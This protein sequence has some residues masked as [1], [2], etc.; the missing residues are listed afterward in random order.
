MA[1]AP[2]N[3]FHESLNIMQTIADNVYNVE[4]NETHLGLNSSGA[5]N[6][7]LMLVQEESAEIEE[8]DNEN[9]EIEKNNNDDTQN[10]EMEKDN[11][12]NQYLET[13][14]NN[15]IINDEIANN[16]EIEENSAENAI[17]STEAEHRFWQL[18]QHLEE[19]E[20]K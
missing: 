18:R 15:E 5:L 6:S 11:D 7:T 17:Y 2:S 20:K 1:L 8:N 14:E 4:N 9:S 16:S 12:N 10:S 13:E 3:L 19:K